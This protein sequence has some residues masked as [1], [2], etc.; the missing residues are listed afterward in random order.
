MKK[1]IT[2]L[3]VFAVM[4]GTGFAQTKSAADVKKA[5]SAAEAAAANPKKAAKL[6][7]WTKLAGTYVAAYDQPTGT[8]W[9]GATKQELQ[10]TGLKAPVSSEQVT[11]LGE[12]YVKDVYA[13]KNLYFNAH[14]QLVMIEVTRP[15]I[16]DALE[17]AVEAYRKAAE[18]DPAGKKSKDIAAGLEGIENK[19]LNE[20]MND[21]TLGKYAAASDKFAAAAETAA[22]PPLSKVDTTA[23]YNAGYTA[24]FY[25]NT[26]AASDSLAAVESYRKAT[27]YF[28]SCAANNYYYE[29]G[30]VFAKLHDCYKKLGRKDD[31]KAIL[32]QGFTAYPQSQSILI[33]LINYYIE[34]QEDPQKLFALLDAAKVNEPNNASLYY[35]EGNIYN[36]LGDTENAAKAYNQCS[37]INP[38]YEYGYIGAGIMYYNRAVEISEKAALEMNDAKYEVLMNECETALLDAKTPFEKAFE[39][40]KDNEIK[41]NIAA[42]LKNI[43]YRF[44]SKG[45]EWEEGYNKYSEIV[46]NGIAE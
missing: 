33:A 8:L 42:Y 13:D 10:L 39:V 32:E 14:N 12:V 36:Q 2:A 46:K 44:Y 31:A 5:V 38:D 28:E 15:V 22:L 27:G 19:Y 40:T 41:V 18:L 11:L 29:G 9:I 7:T 35:V 24:W 34:N 25:G 1:L 17:K 26:I 45:A 21:Y 30:E 16:P 6:A 43:Y 23:L 4:T 3:A 37:V 20:G